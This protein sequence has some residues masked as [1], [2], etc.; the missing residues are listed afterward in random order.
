M[1]KPGISYFLALVA[2]TFLMGSSFIAGKILL[3]SGFAPFP[4]LGWRFLLAATLTLPL[5]AAANQSPVAALFP[6]QLAIRHWMTVI[7]IGLL[8]TTAVMGLVFQAM[9]TIPASTAAILLFSNPIL[10]ALL[11]R[12]FLSEP[13]SRLRALGLISGFTGV[14]LAI[15]ISGLDVQS[16]R[17]LT[18]ELTALTAALCWALATI[19][20]K[21]ASV[22]MNTWVF[23]FWQMLIGGLSLLGAAYVEGEG[24]P[25][26]L[27]PAGWGWFLWLAIPASTGAFG[28]WFVALRMGG[29]TRTSGYLFLTPLFTVLLSSFILGSGLSWQQAFGGFLIG[30][31]LW[32]VNR[33][34]VARRGERQHE[35]LA[36]G[37]PW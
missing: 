7:L 12:L 3:R 4:L 5:V 15:G 1:R 24:W 36:E 8:Q 16:I 9:R 18:G 26:G 22:P 2:S 30:V 11:G 21:R 25:A 17:M 35:T 13:L 14:A 31:G 33:E 20:T 34:P 37:Q 28:L 10:V 19:V 27:A 32:L 6:R 29:A 23:N